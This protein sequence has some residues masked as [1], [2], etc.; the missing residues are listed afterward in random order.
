MVF[1]AIKRRDVAAQWNFDLDRAAGAL[2]SVVAR[3]SFAKPAS[4]DAYNRIYLGVEVFAAPERLNAD[5]VALDLRGFAV[6]YQLH[7]EAEKRHEL[8]RTAE[9]GTGNNVFDGG[10]N[11]FRRERIIT[12]VRSRHWIRLFTCRSENFAGRTVFLE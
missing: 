9:A 12:V 3:Q 2:A 8:G 7:H 5:G 4:L 10:A 1:A 6:E 11:L